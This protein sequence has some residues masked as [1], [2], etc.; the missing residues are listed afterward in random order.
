MPAD[1]GTGP[2]DLLERDGE[3]AALDP[4]TLSQAVA[5]LPSGTAA[6]G[7]SNIVDLL[8]ATGLAPGRSAA[9]RTIAEGGAYLNNVKVTDEDHVLEANDVLADRYVL[10][11]RG[12][13]NLA[14]A[15]VA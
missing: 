4:D 13:R 1:A 10:L 3:L 2:P 8:I 7:E 11:R 15:V 14:V 9:R 5:E 12:R 6:V